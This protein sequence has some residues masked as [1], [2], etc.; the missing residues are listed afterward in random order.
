MKKLF[1]LVIK[2][3]KDLL[4]ARN[5]IH[6][7]GEWEEYFLMTLI[8]TLEIGKRFSFLTVMEQGIKEPENIQSNIKT[9]L[10]ILEVI[11]LQFRDCKVFNKKL[12]FFLRL[13]ESSSVGNLQVAQQVFTGWIMLLKKLKKPKFM[14]YQ[15]QEFF[16]IP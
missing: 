10:C 8:I 16:T 12:V 15:V 14:L 4:E 9:T 13:K 3:P 11:I 6:Q 2:G 5:S 1:K 7:K